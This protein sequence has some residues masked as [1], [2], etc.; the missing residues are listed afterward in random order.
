MSG[1]FEKTVFRILAY[2]SIVVALA[3]V[4]LPLLPATPFVLLAGF[5]ASKGSPEFAR[6]LEDHP[7]FGPVIEDWRSRRVIPAHAKVVACSMMALSWALL[8]VLG[9][10]GVAVAATGA[11]LCGVAGYL[12]TRP[13]T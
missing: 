7:T 2:M 12:V 3:G 6:W 13:S 8:I 4:I 5:F 1:H 9:M 11:I 10:P